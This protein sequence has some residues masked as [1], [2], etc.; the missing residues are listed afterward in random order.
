MIRRVPQEET[1]DSIAIRAGSNF[2]WGCMTDKERKEKDEKDGKKDVEE[3]N[4]S[5]LSNE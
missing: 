1:P 4:K 5:L 2:H 3:E